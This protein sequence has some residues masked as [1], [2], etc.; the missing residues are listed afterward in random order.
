MVQGHP[1]QAEGQG[2]SIYATSLVFDATDHAIECA[3]WVTCEC[4]DPFAH[5]QFTAGGW[6]HWRHDEH[7]ACTCKAGPIGYQASHILPSDEDPRAG[8]FDLSHI[9]GFISHAG[10]P[11]I[12]DDDEDYPAHPWLR[13][14]LNRETVVL[15]RAQVIEVRDYLTAW[16][17]VA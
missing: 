6:K 5:R 14:G 4:N 9:P 15:D 10:R 12:N 1:G 2:V 8:T 3:R 16:L 7:A 13:I 11:P 17:E